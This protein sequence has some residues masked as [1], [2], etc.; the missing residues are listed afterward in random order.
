MPELEN[1]AP[2]GASENVP[3]ILSVES[4]AARLTAMDETPASPE[5]VTQPEATDQNA[6]QPP[7]G[8]EPPPAEENAPE[9]APGFDWE[10]VPAE[11]T[12]RLRDQTTFTAAD[13]KKNWD[14]FRKLPTTRQEIAA[15]R[16]RI[17]QEREDSAQ[18]QQFLSQSLPVAL[19]IL[20]ASI[21]S[22][23]VRPVYD[24]TDPLG[25][26]EK[27]SAYDAE[28]EGYNNRVLAF[29]NLQQAQATLAQQAQAEHAERSKTDIAEQRVELF[30]KLP[31]L[32]DDKKREEFYRDFRDFALK[33]G[34]SDRD[35]GTATDHR[36]I[37]M[38][39]KA[40]KYDKLM[41]S[42][43][44]PIA[45]VRTAPTAPVAVPG[46]R[47][48]PKEAEA[49]KRADLF[50]R[51]RSTPGGITQRDAARLIAELE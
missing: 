33:L 51:A 24:P 1:A 9:P 10:N 12:F 17:Q 38:A 32:R 28:V 29:Q 44:A 50:Q 3:E 18:K 47:V 7:E 42:Q 2:A 21:G 41:A 30:K 20:Q 37:V 26:I 39:D 19:H 43:P 22:P 48:A 5:V 35:V 16:Q 25:H 34:Y 13:L 23:P 40:M 15:E 27:Q 45:P 4:A 46:Q 11:A 31:H 49:A 36:I 8:A 6:A 14:E